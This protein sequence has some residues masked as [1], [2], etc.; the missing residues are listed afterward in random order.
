M[1]YKSTRNARRSKSGRIPCMPIDFGERSFRKNREIASTKSKGVVLWWGF[2]DRFEISKEFSER[3]SVYWIWQ[4]FVFVVCIW[5]SWCPEWEFLWYFMIFFYVIRT[6][7]EQ[8][9]WIIESTHWPIIIL[10]QTQIA[11]LYYNIKTYFF[12]INGN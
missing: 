1:R 9:F 5:S 3:E 11:K 7:N 10:W 12:H 6:I 2:R 4:E 8:N